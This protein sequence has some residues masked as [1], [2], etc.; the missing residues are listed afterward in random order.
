[1]AC[2]YFGGEAASGGRRGEGQKEARDIN[3]IKGY[4]PMR[5]WN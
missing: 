2:Q 5:E 4:K 1:M 3:S